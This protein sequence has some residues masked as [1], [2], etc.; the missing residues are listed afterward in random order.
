MKEYIALDSH[1]RYTLAEREEVDSGEV[2][3]QRIE[4]RRGA[5]REY[6][7]EGEPGT[8]VAVEATGNWYWIV[9]EIEQA[10][11][12]PRL[13]HPR[14][15]KLMM[16]MINKTDKLD[17]HGMNRLQRNRSLPTV[18]IPPA[19]LRDLRELTR[20]RMVFSQQRARL[21]NRLQA[22]LS[23]YGLLA[24]G[25]SDLFGQAG[26]KLLDRLM[27]ELPE[28][29]AW[30]SR[31]LLE[32][33]DLVEKHLEEQEERLKEV[34]EATEEMKW[35]ASLPGVGLILSGVMALEIGQVERFGDAER[36][37][38]YAGTTP[39]VIS[40]GGK[41]RYGPL[42]PDVNRYLKWAYLEA[43][44]VV[45]IHHQRWSGS[46]GSYRHVSVLYERIRRR[47]GHAKAIGAVARHLAESSWHVLSRKENYR[48]PGVP[49][50]RVASAGCKRG[51]VMSAR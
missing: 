3:Q 16:G 30:T 10:G 25:V 43:A 8:A 9:S 34:M 48:S 4:H 41:T 6:L 33:L 11:K 12:T 14:K 46:V 2:V 13:V 38:S 39:R 26:R 29:T 20:G 22:T 45:A 47:K 23:K 5:I 18:W 42:R 27:K 1:K 44:N 7:K 19:G 17:V 28:Q 35:L 24:E 21:K 32:Q 36:L 49:A 37:A 51:I 31:M 50:K 15:A 40:S